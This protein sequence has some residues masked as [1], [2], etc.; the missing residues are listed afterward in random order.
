M[1]KKI[2]MERENG[3]EEKMEIR[4]KKRRKERGEER[5]IIMNHEK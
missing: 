5:T 4:V 3:R 2:M 1:A